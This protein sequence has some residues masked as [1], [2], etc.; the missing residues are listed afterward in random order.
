MSKI[1]HNCV[2][3]KYNHIQL[4]IFELNYNQLIVIRFNCTS[5]ILNCTQF[6]WTILNCTSIIPNSIGCNWEI[7]EYNWVR[8]KYNYVQLII[9]RFNYYFNYTQLHP[10]VLN[11]TQYLYLVWVKLHPIE[12]QLRIIEAQLGAIEY[13]WSSIKSNYNHLSLIMHQLHSVVLNFTQLYLIT[14]NWIRL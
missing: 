3:L 2:W 11:N 8:L 6:C 9:I 4:I 12:V 7:I 5:I 14:S 1:E 10:I 13:I